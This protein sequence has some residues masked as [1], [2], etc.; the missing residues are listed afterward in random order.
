VNKN[1]IPAIII[2]RQAQEVQAAVIMAK[3]FPRDEFEA[4]NRIL[5]ACQNE[6]LAEAAIYS[7]PRGKETVRGASIRLA[8]EISRNWGNMESGIIEVEK[9]EGSSTM[10]AY[11][12]DLETNTRSTKFFSVE[13]IR[14]TK[15]GNKP[16]T[17][18]R[19]IYELTANMGARRMRACI[20]AL[21]P[22]EIVN[23]AMNACDE[24]KRLA[25]D[26]STV[27]QVD[28]KK[29]KMVKAFKSAKVTIVMLEKYIKK[30]LDDF[31]KEDLAA[32]STV[33]NSIKDGMS[34]VEDHFKIEQKKSALEKS[35]K[36][37]AKKVEV[38]SNK[39][40]VNDDDI[41]DQFK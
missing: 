39:T 41:P 14:E 10:M 11:A 22:I 40:T 15:Y 25:L 8:E 16:I 1:K 21:I 19:D 4:T 6:V 2:S 12:W 28:T 20:L 27:E 36:E 35:V 34:G 9:K 37:P 5:R 17:G 38:V 31:N 30:S 13:H 33:Y 29:D 26:G 23:K 18:A 24:T 32:L 7:Y 3:K